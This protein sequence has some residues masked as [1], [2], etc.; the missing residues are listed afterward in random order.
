[1]DYNEWLKLKS[2]SEKRDVSKDSI[3][4]DIK[5][6]HKDTGDAANQSGHSPDTYKKPNHP[7]FS[8]QSKYSNPLQMGGH[9]SDQNIFTPSKLN[10][11][12]RS[13]EELQRYFNEVET[14]EQLNLPNQDRLSLARRSALE[15]LKRR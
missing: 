6:Y 11:Q 5:D 2:L 4:Y 3:D 1:M 14:P 13:P 8:D 12:N 15:A 10:L 9:W 7:T